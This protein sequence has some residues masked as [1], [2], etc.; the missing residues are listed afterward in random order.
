VLDILVP[1]RRNATAA[2]RFVKQLLQGLQ[3]KPR[4]L[5]TGTVRLI[6]RGDFLGRERTAGRRHVAIWAQVSSFQT[7]KALARAWR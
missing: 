1:D 2:E 5:V 4:H 6:D 7:L 3:Y